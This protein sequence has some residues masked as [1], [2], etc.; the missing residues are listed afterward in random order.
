MF[1]GDPFPNIA[2]HVISA[3]VISI[4]TAALVS[5]LVL[6]ETGSPV[7]L[8]KVPEDHG[9]GRHSNTIAAL[10][11]GSWDGLKLA[12]GIA[13]LLIAVLGLVAVLDLVLVKLSTPFAETLG[14][15]IE[16]SRILG[17]LFTPLAGLLGIEG[18]DIREAGRLLGE[19]S[20]LTEIPA[21][22]RLGELA[23]AG[24]VSPRTLLILSYALCGFA[25]I[26]SLGIFVGGV[27]ALAPSRRDDLAAVGLRALVGA[28]LATLMTG[29]L[30][31]LFYWGQEGILGIQ[32]GG[33][34]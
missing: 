5:K 23:A 9:L 34:M 18:A 26:A 4:P 6:P 19:R 22:R 10:T 32:A 8:G 16:S 3:S 1:L 21:Y 27:A 20:I 15:P 29:A 14:G 24:T 2:G 28:T 31:G 11:S 17:W 13:T 7:T 30:A 25:H 12:A 33:S